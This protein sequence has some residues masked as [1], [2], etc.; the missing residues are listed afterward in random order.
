VNRQKEKDI[1]RLPSERLGERISAKLRKSIPLLLIV[2]RLGPIPRP[3]PKTIRFKG[4]G[5]ATKWGLSKNIDFP[6]GVPP[7]IG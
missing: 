7:G 4:P 5:L 6:L 1:L 3:G 2:R